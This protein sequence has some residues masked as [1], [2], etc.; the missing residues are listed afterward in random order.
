[1]LYIFL[2]LNSQPLG[3]YIVIY[4][5]YHEWKMCIIGCRRN[6]N[7]SSGNASYSEVDILITKVKANIF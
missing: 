3:R 7:N 2:F 4:K 5:V 1:M 6:Y